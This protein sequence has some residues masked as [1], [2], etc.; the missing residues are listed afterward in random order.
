MMPRDGFP[1]LFKQLL[2]SAVMHSPGSSDQHPGDS[3]R[4]ADEAGS[5]F[6]ARRRDV[7]CAVIMITGTVILRSASVQQ[8]NANTRRDRYP[9]APDRACIPEI[10]K[11]V[12]SLLHTDTP[13]PR[14]VGSVQGVGQMTSSS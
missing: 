5:S 11:K 9:A 10:L 4:T 1:E 2:W 13:Y 8:L 3:G 12:L 14:S 6:I 7:E